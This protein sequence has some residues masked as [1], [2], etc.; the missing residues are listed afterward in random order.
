[1]DQI[2]VKFSNQGSILNRGNNIVQADRLTNSQ[3][4]EHDSFLPKS[5]SV[6]FL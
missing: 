5:G 4:V 2:L 3:Y 6:D 1:M